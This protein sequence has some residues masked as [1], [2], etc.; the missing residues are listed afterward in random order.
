M[1]N[2]PLAQINDP[3]LR[4]VHNLH[5]AAAPAQ[6][7]HL[8]DV[9]HV[10][11]IR[12]SFLHVRRGLDRFQQPLAIDRFGKTFVRAISSR[13]SAAAISLSEPPRDNPSTPSP[14]SCVSRRSQRACFCA[15]CCAAESLSTTSQACSV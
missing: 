12:R 14:S 6:A 15:H 2:L 7:T 9:E 1:N 13:C 8:K 10:K 4:R 5:R 3:A 11:Q